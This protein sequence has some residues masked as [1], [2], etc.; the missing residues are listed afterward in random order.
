MHS[1]S[2]PTDA[3]F[4]DAFRTHERQERINT[5]K[6]AAAL[7]VFLMPAGVLLDYFVFVFGN[8]QGDWRLVREFFILRLL[9][10]ALVGV[11]WYLHTTRLAERY[12]RYLGPPIA[13]L[14]AFFISWMIYELGD[15]QSPYR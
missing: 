2:L 3:R 8:P 13:L 7:V 14:P 10:S 11:I 1:E 15:P 12:C 9:C 5:G 4:L 6:N